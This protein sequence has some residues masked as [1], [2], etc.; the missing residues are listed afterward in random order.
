MN[1]SRWTGCGLGL[2]VAAGAALIGVVKARWVRAT[3][4]QLALLTASQQVSPAR[5]YDARQIDDLPA[6]VQRYFR[7]VLKHGQPFIITATFELA[8]SINMSAAGEDW[9]RFTSSQRAVVNRPGFLWNG[10]VSMFPGLKAHVHGSYIAGV[11]RLHGR[12]LGLFTVADAEGGGEIASGELMRY[13]AEM[14]WYPTALLPRLL[15]KACA[16]KRSMTGQPAPH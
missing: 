14:V 5:R 4:R 3:K 2:A 13:F 10:S 12:M 16:G 9:K 6:P 15:A 7:A 11:G 8:G 1:W